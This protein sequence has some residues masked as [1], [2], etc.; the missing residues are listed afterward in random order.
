MGMRLLYTAAIRGTLNEAG[1]AG[2][3]GMDAHCILYYCGQDFNRLIN[4]LRMK[5][6]GG[7]KTTKANA[8]ALADQ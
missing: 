6:K 2:R 5:R 1:R 7:T 3:D 4:M 8:R